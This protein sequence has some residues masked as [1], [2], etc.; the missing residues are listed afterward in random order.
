MDECDGYMPDVI[1]GC[2]QYVDEWWA[3]RGMN[4]CHNCGN[5]FLFRVNRRLIWEDETF[6]LESE[7]YYG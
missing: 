7:D 5:D 3:E 2:L 4:L 6:Q 1:N